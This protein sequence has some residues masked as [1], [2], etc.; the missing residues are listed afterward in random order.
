[1]NWRHILIVIA[2]LLIYLV[3]V[4]MN[5]SSL[6][7]DHQKIPPPHCLVICVQKQLSMSNLHKPTLQKVNVCKYPSIGKMEILSNDGLCL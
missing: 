7:E 5:N 3:Q 4:C 6:S 1:M 2:N